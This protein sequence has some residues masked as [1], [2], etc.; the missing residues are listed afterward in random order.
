MKELTMEQTF[1]VTY[2]CT[3]IIGLGLGFLTYL[4]FEYENNNNNNDDGEETK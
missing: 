2:L 1:I 4:L 3:T